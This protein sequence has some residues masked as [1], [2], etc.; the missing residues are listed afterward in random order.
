MAQ[1]NPTYHGK[2]NFEQNGVTPTRGQGL[3]QSRSIRLKGG[4]QLLKKK[5]LRTGFEVKFKFLD[6]ADKSTQYN[7][8]AELVE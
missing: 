1:R 2:I 4:R 3:S 6:V 8:L 5:G 7:Y